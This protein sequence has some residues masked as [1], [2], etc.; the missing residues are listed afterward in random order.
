MASGVLQEFSCAAKGCEAISFFV[1][2]S[3]AFVAS[4][5]IVEEG[6]GGGTWDMALAEGGG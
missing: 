2:F 3:Y 6:V 5:K 4:L 1:R